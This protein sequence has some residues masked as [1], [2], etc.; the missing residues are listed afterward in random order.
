MRRSTALLPAPERQRQAQRVTQILQAVIERERPAVVAL[1]SPLHDEI[2]IGRVTRSA[3]CRIVLPRVEST[4][5]D[6]ARMEFYDFS[7]E[8]MARGAFGIDEPQHGSP[9]PPA[10]IDLMILPGMAFTREGLRLGR[11][12]GYYDRY[13]AREGFRARCIGVCF[14]HQLLDALPAERHD[15]RMEAVV[16]ADGQVEIPTPHEP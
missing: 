15:R 7:P 11:G 2:D 3:P 4:D 6:E 13:T 10:D 5:G 1:F 16:T 9:C 14:V 8:A 12:K